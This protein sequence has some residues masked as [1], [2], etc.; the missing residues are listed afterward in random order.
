MSMHGQV[1]SKKNRYR[2]KGDFHHITPNTPIRDADADWRLIGVT[3]PRDMTYIHSYGGRRFSSSRL[4]RG[5]CWPPAA[6]T[7][8]VNRPVVSTCRFASIVRI[9]SAE[10][11]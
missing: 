4:A 2:L 1:Y 5:N 9:A 11:R 10:T 8:S 3:N 6:T 7:P